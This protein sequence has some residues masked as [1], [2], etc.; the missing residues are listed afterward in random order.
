MKMHD[1]DEQFRELLRQM[2]NYS[3]DG[4]T[5]EWAASVKKWEQWLQKQIENDD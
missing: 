3:Y 2:G 1:F 4:L 5:D